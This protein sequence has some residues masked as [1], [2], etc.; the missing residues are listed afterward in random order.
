MIRCDT[1][2]PGKTLATAMATLVTCLLFFFACTT[3]P[4]VPKRASEEATLLIIPLGDPGYRFWD[5][6]ATYEIHCDGVWTGSVADF[7][8]KYAFLTGVVAGPHRI[9]R[10]VLP[11]HIMSNNPSV[12]VKSY[13]VDVD[14]DIPFTVVAGEAVMLPICLSV[15]PTANPP[16]VELRQLSEGEIVEIL[17][18][19]GTFRNIETWR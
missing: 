1:T 16:R 3:T 5:A 17:A 8:K 7:S 13:P 14:C 15:F 19:L 11:S 18:D 2:L 10:L 6:A 4:S 9:T 12:V